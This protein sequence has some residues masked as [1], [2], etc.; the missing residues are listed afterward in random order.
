M[1]KGESS[2][3][4]ID[5]CKLY[6]NFD[7]FSAFGNVYYPLKSNSNETIL[8]ALFDK[9]LKTKN[10]FLISSVSHFRILEKMGVDPEQI[11]L[12]NVFLSKEDILYLYKHGVRQYTFDNLDTLKQISN[13]MNLS[14]LKINIRL[15]SQ[16]VFHSYFT[17]LG[18]DLEE[19]KK[20]IGFLKNKHADVGISIYL[21]CKIQKK[22]NY[23]NKTINYL[24]NNFSNCEIKRI[25]IGGICPPETLMKTDILKLRQKMCLD[26]VILEPGRY[27]VENA[28]ELKTKIIRTKKKPNHH[29]L[30]IRNGIYSGFFDK[31]LYHRK[32]KFS[33]LGENKIEI[34]MY[35]E[36]TIKHPY[37]IE[38]Y[39]G[40]SDSGDIIGK[41]YINKENAKYL[42]TG[43]F[44]YIKDVG[45]Y[46]EEFTMNYGKDIHTKHIFKN[47]ERRDISEI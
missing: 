31:I 42:C 37:C 7:K 5:R 32:F 19:T 43:R 8:S 25:S 41:L 9:I 11:E 16:C 10:G 4:Y 44:L 40:S 28:V 35:N 39:G 26:E 24:I 47:Y 12:I 38:I 29:Y 17:H 6:E 30:V 20:M 45:A 15:S 22:I 13:I 2:C 34:P 3:Y 36:K 27:L 21:P 18:A 14:E 23:I 33:F 46:F 1:L